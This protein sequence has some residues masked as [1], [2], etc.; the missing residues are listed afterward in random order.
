MLDPFYRYYS[1]TPRSR[2][3]FLLA[4]IPDGKSMSEGLRSDGSVVARRPPEQEVAGSIPG[5]VS[6]CG[7]MAM[8][9]IHLTLDTS[10][11]DSSCFVKLYTRMNRWVWRGKWFNKSLAQ[12][13]QE[14]S[15]LCLALPSMRPY[16][17]E[18]TA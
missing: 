10:F 6:P 7:W 9:E 15:D 1:T 8:L 2:V 11:L 3:R 13:C 4:R 18:V 12:P 5:Q 17:E 14:R 16:T